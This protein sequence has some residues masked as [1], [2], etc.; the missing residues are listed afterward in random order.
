MRSMFLS[1]VALQVISLAH[2]EGNQPLRPSRS[3]SPSY[4][5]VGAH[6]ELSA[7]PNILHLP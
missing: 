2:S 5:P 1:R 4:Q 7:H 3:R 6:R